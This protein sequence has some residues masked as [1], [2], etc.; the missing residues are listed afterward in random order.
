[1]KFKKTQ[2]EIEESKESI[3]RIDDF[4]DRPFLASQKK[5]I[6]NMGSVVEEYNKKIIGLEEST[7]LLCH[8]ISEK[9][10]IIREMRFS[11]FEE[12]NK[13]FEA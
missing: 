2:L 8:Q 13:E 3:K 6:S 7:E 4:S 10:C 5:Y 12:S 9:E 1:M 11:L